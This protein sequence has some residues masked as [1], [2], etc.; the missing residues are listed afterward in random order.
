MTEGSQE[1][2]RLR[3]EFSKP[4]VYGTNSV[5][6]LSVEIPFVLPAGKY[7][8]PNIKEYESSPQAWL[9][10]WLLE[11][12][13]LK[14]DD[15]EEKKKSISAKALECCLG[16]IHFIP[17]VKMDSE[18]LRVH[19]KFFALS[20]LM[21]TLF[22]NSEERPPL[23]KGDL[24]KLDGIAIG[25]DII[26]GRL[27]TSKDIPEG[28]PIPPEFKLIVDSFFTIAADARKYVFDFSRLC[29]PFARKA[30]ETFTG[31]AQ[32]ILDE[33]CPELGK[34]PPEL[35]CYFHKFSSGVE[36]LIELAALVDGISLGESVR[37]NLLFKRA[38]ELCSE[39]IDQTSDIFSLRQDIQDGVEKKNIIIYNVNELG[40]S[41]SESLDNVSK[42]LTR[43]IQVFISICHRLRLLN[44]KNK[45]L[46]KFLSVLENYIDGNLIWLSQRMFSKLES[47]SELNT[48][49]S[50]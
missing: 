3:L 34:L 17:T 1:Q 32:L 8:V 5:T 10:E 48:N 30:D 28:T 21:L 27:K 18:K 44:E 26:E 15:T 33:C 49:I 45:R 39:I 16:S 25:S 29:K 46:D 50:M 43:E 31:I 35:F 19:M 20:S 13:F 4:I 38:L 2:R 9:E 12:G 40:I 37:E 11:S 7:P 41:L 47:I 23:S 22:T 42:D 6:K 14:E 24:Q 36:P